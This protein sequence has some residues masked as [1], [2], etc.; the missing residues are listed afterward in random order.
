MDIPV[1]IE[2]RALDELRSSHPVVIIDTRDPDDYAAEHV[3]GAINLREFFTYLID[4]S[5][6]ETM[7]RLQQSFSDALGAAGLSGR[8]VA[9]VYEDALDTGYGQ[10]CRGYFLLSYLGYPHI[11]ILHGGYQAWKNEGLPTTDEVPQ[12]AP[13]VFPVNVD[14]KVLVTKEQM[15]RSLDDPAIVKLDVRDH[16]EWLGTSSSPYGVDFCPRKGRI[17]GSVWIEWYRM[18]ESDGATPRFCSAEKI[19]E[20]CREVGLRPEDTV[21]VFC[22]KGSR[23]ANTMVALKRAGF[24]DVRNYFA[25]WNEWSR[26]PSLPI[27]TGEPDPARMAARE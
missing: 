5:G 16:D 21:Y 6:P 18:M 9:V 14:N 23:A 3:P 20:V 13:Q 15:L 11:S 10:S 26:D 4:D 8:E 24:R 27:E 7:Q 25:S 2:P 12:P 22:F 17:P 1:L 19:L